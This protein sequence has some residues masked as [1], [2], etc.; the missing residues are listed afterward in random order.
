MVLSGAEI[1]C[2]ALLFIGDIWQADPKETGHYQMS[3]ETDT[4]NY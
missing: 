2:H 3:N 4:A 1:C